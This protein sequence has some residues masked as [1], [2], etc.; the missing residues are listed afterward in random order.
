MLLGTPT[1]VGGV[2]SN[3]Q[4]TVRDAVDVLPQPSVAVHVLVCERAQPL[5]PTAPSVDVS[6]GVPQA[7]VAVAPSSEALICA[8]VGLHCCRAGAVPSVIVG[9]V[10]SDVQFT[11]RDAVDVLP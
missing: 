2:T 9:G 1:N 3:V 11:V 7:S 8:V 10:T 5:L 6:D 4:F